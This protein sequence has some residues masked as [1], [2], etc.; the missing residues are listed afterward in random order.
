MILTSSWLSLYGK[1]AS[2]FNS[3]LLII[4]K[5]MNRRRQG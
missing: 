3:F 1:S 5:I 2:K 4:D